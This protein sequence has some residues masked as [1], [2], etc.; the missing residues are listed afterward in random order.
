MLLLGLHE[1]A[2]R[3]IRSFPAR[4]TAA[5]YFL[6]QEGEWDS[7]GQVLWI[8]ARQSA[9]M[10]RT[11]EPALDRAL[12]KAVH[13]LARKKLTRDDPP[14]TRG[15]LPAGFSA[16][17]LGPNDYYYW[18]DFWAWGGLKEMAK[19]WRRRCHH[20]AA[21]EAEKL[22]AEFATDITR[23]IDSIPEHRAK[24]AIPAAPGRRL[25]AGAV[26]SLVA[27][28][29]LQ[30]FPHGAPRVMA[31]LDWLMDRCFHGGGFFQEMIHSGINAYL[32]LDLAQTLLRAGD[33]R[34]V[35]LIRRVAELASPTGQWPEA[36][37]PATLGGCMGDGQHG[38]AA[39]EW[40]MMIR[41]CFVRE[42]E[43]H[44][45]IGSGILPEWMNGSVRFGPTLTP[46]GGVSVTLA[47]GRLHLDGRWHESPPHVI[48]AV[49]GYHSIAA[50]GAKRSF[51]LEPI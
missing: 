2:D 40:L 51:D 16:E 38:W 30:L 32:T 15:L 42:E 31:T 8:A 4:Q 1:R 18:D 9:L 12:R 43:H 24:G 44:L 50:N 35:T 49:P 26:G 36:I 23:S 19:Q 20:E 21:D 3:I 33:P 41:N 22:C 7:N 17:H 28:Y 45:V 39:A 25:D 6:S 29:P 47:G 27:D 11:P 34:F 46:W 10:N 5:G 48:V 14:G 37:H 13:W